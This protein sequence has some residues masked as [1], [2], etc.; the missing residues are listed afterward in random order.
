MVECGEAFLKIL[1]EHA[2][3]DR[4]FRLEEEVRI[5]LSESLHH[6]RSYICMSKPM[7]ITSF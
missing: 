5:A 6:L 1:N 4:V 2:K 3:A 7:R